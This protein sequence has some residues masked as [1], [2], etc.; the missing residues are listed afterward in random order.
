MR[1]A[2]LFVL[3]LIALWSCA[4]NTPE[5]QNEATA[6]PG[7]DYA[8]L[9]DSISLAARQALVGRLAAAIEAGGPGHAALFCSENAT[10]LTDSLSR[11]YGVEIRRGAE[12][13]RNPD[14]ALSQRETEV[15]EM[16]RSDASLP[17]YVS[18]LDGYHVYYCPIM[19]GMPLCL[20]CHG[21][22]QERHPEAMD[23][24]SRAYPNDRA[25]GFAL[26]D[27]RG[28]WRITFGKVD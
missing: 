3:S 21:N 22:D 11:V 18:S 4:P 9:G 7:K 13:N 20:Q 12:R 14:N 2:S 1:N 24:I 6:S 17:N 26:G 25:V 10:A 15:F 27:L 16:F 23:V 28:M 19:T 8:A 5:R